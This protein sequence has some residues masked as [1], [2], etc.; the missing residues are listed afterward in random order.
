ME[1]ISIPRAKRDLYLGEIENVISRNL[2]NEIII[3]AG[4]H[5]EWPDKQIIAEVYRA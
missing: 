2:Y 4:K 1:Q 5:V 3:E